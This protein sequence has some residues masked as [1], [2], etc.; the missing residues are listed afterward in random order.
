MRRILEITG[1]LVGIIAGGITIY[2]FATRSSEGETPPPPP[3]PTPTVALPLESIAGTYDL[4]SWTG[5]EQSGEPLNV[6]AKSGR[7]T[8]SPSG[9]IAWELALQGKDET[10]NPISGITCKGEY[11]LSESKIRGIAGGT[12]VK[13]S[14][15][16]ESVK[17]YVWMS[18][19]GYHLGQTSLP[20]ALTMQ[21]NMLQMEN[22]RGVFKWQ[23]K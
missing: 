23:K 15:S 12:S 16:I 17:D 9:E 6:D 22:V 2:L 20:V 13:W 4:V 19:C 11:D 10:G 14:R 1:I 7:L 21:D 18:F 8:V 5:N 3:P